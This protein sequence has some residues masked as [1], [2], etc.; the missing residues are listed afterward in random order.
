[1]SPTDLEYII[2]HANDRVI[3]ADEVIRFGFEEMKLDAISAYTPDYNHASVQALEK[4]QFKKTE[5]H[6][7]IHRK[8]LLSS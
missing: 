1:L 2:N 6:S 7:G 4:F 3:F 5:E 8:W